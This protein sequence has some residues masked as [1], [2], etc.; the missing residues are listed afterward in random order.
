M[1]LF[2]KEQD[3][4]TLPKEQSIAFQFVWLSNLSTLMLSMFF[5]SCLIAVPLLLLIVHFVTKLGN[6]VELTKHIK[7]SY[8]VESN[9]PITNNECK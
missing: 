3:I 5:V 7:F 2:A 1:F 9:V 6:L 4:K 8:V